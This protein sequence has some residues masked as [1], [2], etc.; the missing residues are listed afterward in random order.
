MSKQ[1]SSCLIIVENDKPIGIV[2]ERDITK[3][4]CTLLKDAH[5]PEHSI[6]EIMTSTPVCVQEDSLFKDALMLSRSRKLRHLPVINNAG[7]L[8]G[9]VTQS[10]L[11]DVYVRLI[12]RH[13]ELETN[14]EELKLLSLEDALLG[15]G[16]RRAMEVDLTHTEQHAL[17]T[18]NS[19]SLALV[20]IDFFKKYNDYYGHQSGDD[21]LRQ[22]A[23]TV[24]STLRTSD[25]VFR[26]GGEELLILMPGSIGQQARICAERVRA[27]IEAL[28]IP[29]IE[30]DKGVLTVS[31]GVVESRVEAWQDLV[32]QADKALYQAKSQGRNQVTVADQL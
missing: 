16:N 8:V 9:V 27:A 24:K 10:N 28:Q 22:V 19:Y 12:D 4:F 2:T 6:C 17:R 1:G 31:I 20:D 30:S 7:H 29:H 3:L 5:Y 13:A 26:Y 21:A 32:K 14:V 15:I 23:Q 11:V 18:Q 25:R